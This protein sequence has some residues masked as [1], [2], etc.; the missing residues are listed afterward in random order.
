MD[1]AGFSA[2]QHSEEDLPSTP[3]DDGGWVLSM[4]D[5]HGLI[6]GTTGSGKSGLLNKLAPPSLAKAVD[7]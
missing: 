7:L 6:A 3:T 1:H 2:P 5:G 4:W